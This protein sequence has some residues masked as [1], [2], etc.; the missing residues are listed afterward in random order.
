MRQLSEVPAGA[1]DLLAIIKSDRSQLRERTT[2]DFAAVEEEFGTR[3]EAA[4]ESEAGTIF[5]LVQPAYESELGVNVQVFPGTGHHAAEAELLG[6]LGL[7]TTDLSWR[8]TALHLNQGDIVSIDPGA[9]DRYQPDGVGVVIDISYEDHPDLVPVPGVNPAVYTVQIDGAGLIHVPSNFLQWEPILHAESVRSAAG[10]SNFLS[11]LA[12]HVA[13]Q[14]DYW[15]SGLGAGGVLSSMVT[16]LGEREAVA[17]RARTPLQPSWGL[18][19]A[20]LLEVFAPPSW[21]SPDSED[22]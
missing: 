20:V 4:F 21:S 12:H 18:L 19:A 7:E 15:N 10:F 8:A 2:L 1:T 5:A 11:A 22:G 9:P 17:A 3:Y 16:R 6:A 14:P 13:V